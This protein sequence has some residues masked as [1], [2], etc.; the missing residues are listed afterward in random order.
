MY[1]VGTDC[2]DGF[3]ILVCGDDRS[4]AAT[5]RHQFPEQ[6][7]PLIRRQNLLAQAEPAA[8]AREDGLGGLFERST[9][10]VSALPTCR[11]R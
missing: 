7:A 3:D 6:D 1:P 11:S 2:R 4:E 8:A 5:E 9:P 10:S